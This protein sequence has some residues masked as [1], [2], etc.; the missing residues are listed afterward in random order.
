MMV[1]FVGCGNNN[2]STPDV[3]PETVTPKCVYVSSN[4][5]GDGTLENPCS[6]TYAINN[7]TQEMPVCLMGGT[8]NVNSNNIKQSGNRN[9]KL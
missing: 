9:L 2:S 7:M 8:Y 3:E 4:G 1:L 5:T 6:L